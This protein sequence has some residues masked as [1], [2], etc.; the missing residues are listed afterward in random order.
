LIPNLDDSRIGILL[1]RSDGESFWAIRDLIQR[2]NP[3]EYQVE[4]Y[5]LQLYAIACHVR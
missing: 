4:Q 1:C 5:L 2:L 3:I